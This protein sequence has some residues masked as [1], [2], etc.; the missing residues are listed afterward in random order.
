MLTGVQLCT[1][2]CEELAALV[3]VINILCAA[4][5]LHCVYVCECVSMGVYKLT[6]EGVQELSLWLVY[7]MRGY[8]WQGLIE[9]A[10]DCVY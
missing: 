10:L 8:K 3:H 7:N 2:K 4:V 1:L 5:L 9:E 6:H